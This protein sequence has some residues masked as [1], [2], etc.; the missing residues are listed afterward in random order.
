MPRDNFKNSNVNWYNTLK[1]STK[2]GV[3]DQSAKLKPI[4]G[5]FTSLV[6]Y[7]VSRKINLVKLD[8]KLVVINTILAI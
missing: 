5:V 4:R 7:S 3:A 8:F 2:G 1:K 6:I